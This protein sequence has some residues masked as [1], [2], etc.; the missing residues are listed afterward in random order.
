MSEYSEP[1]VYV[2]E[3]RFRPKIIEGMSTGTAGFV[4][5]ARFGPIKG[6]PVLLTSYAD[7]EGIYRGFEQLVFGN[8]NPVH[9]YTAHAIRD[10]FRKGGK[11]LYV[12]LV[13]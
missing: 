8:R 12:S 5:P 11:R 4:G 1:G 6:K 2:E 10:F 13:Q 3:I 9:N 7:F